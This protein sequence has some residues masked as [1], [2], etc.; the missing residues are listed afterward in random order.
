MSGLDEQAAALAAVLNLGDTL[1]FELLKV[2]MSQT[3]LFEA[4]RAG[5]L[6]ELI[7]RESQ[8]AVAAAELRRWAR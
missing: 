2:A 3:L 4:F 8:V 7:C 6:A 1:P 5:A